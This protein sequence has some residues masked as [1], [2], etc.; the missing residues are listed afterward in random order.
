M[1]KRLTIYLYPVRVSS[2]AKVGT[3]LCEGEF[4][5][6]SCMSKDSSKLPTV[7]DREVDGRWIADVVDMPGVMAYGA[8]REE[9]IEKAETLAA[10]VLA[11][12]RTRGEDF[13]TTDH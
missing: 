3:S 9:A 2:S 13:P 11:D 4:W 6:T 5:A 12:R 7:V 1:K 10:R 8:T